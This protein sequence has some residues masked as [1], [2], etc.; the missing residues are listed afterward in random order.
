MDYNLLNFNTFLLDFLDITLV[1][2]IFYQVSFL[3]RNTRSTKLIMGAT[4][5]GVLYVLSIAWHLEALGQVFQ[6]I[7][8]VQ[9]GSIIIVILFSQEI[10]DALTSISLNRMA[11]KVNEDSKTIESITQACLKMS[12]NKVG[13]LILIGK[14]D[15]LYDLME[16]AVSLHADVSSQVIESIFFEP[17]LNSKGNNPLH[18]G[19]VIISNNKIIAAKVICKQLSE[20]N[21]LRVHNKGTRHSAGLGFTEQRDC[22]AIIISHETGNIT[23][24]THGEKTLW[25]IDR[26]DLLLEL[27]RILKMYE[28]KTSLSQTIREY[29][30][31]RKFTKFSSLALAILFWCFCKTNITISCEISDP[32]IYVANHTW[33]EEDYVLSVETEGERNK[34]IEFEIVNWMKVYYL[35]NLNIGGKHAFRNA[36]EVAVNEEDVQKQWDSPKKRIKA[37][38]LIAAPFKNDLAFGSVE[39][40]PKVALKIQRLTKVETKNLFRFYISGHQEVDSIEGMSDTVLLMPNGYYLPHLLKIDITDTSVISQATGQDSWQEIRSNDKLIRNYSDFSGMLELSKVK[41]LSSIAMFNNKI[42]IKFRVIV[43][44]TEVP[45][46]EDELSAEKELEAIRETRLPEEISTKINLNP[47]PDRIQIIQASNQKMKTTERLNEIQKQIEFY[48]R[49][50]DQKATE[51][52]KYKQDYDALMISY[53]NLSIA[54]QAKKKEIEIKRV[55]V[56]REQTLYDQILEVLEHN[57]KKTKERL[58]KNEEIYEKYIMAFQPILEIYDI[59]RKKA[60][61]RIA[62][63]PSVNVVSQNFKNI[64]EQTQKVNNIQ[65]SSV[66]DVED[67]FD[68]VIESLDTFLISPQTAKKPGS[69]HESILSKR[70]LLEQLDL[71]IDNLNNHLQPSELPVWLELHKVQT[72]VILEDIFL[73]VERISDLDGKISVEQDNVYQIA[74]YR[75]ALQESIFLKIENLFQAQEKLRSLLH[76]S[77][78]VENKKLEIL[79]KKIFDL[80]TTL[81]RNIEIYHA[82]KAESFHSFKQFTIPEQ[83]DSKNPIINETRKGFEEWPIK[84]LDY[85]QPSDRANFQMGYNLIKNFFTFDNNGWEKLNEST[86][87][88]EKQNAKN[89]QEYANLIAK[90]E[91]LVNAIALP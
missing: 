19:A 55:Q 32:N 25:N 26:A 49:K 41:E 61:V 27:K 5:I 85:T 22:V 11:Y 82:K 24:A 71:A 45:K 14:Q 17:N 86:L 44:D 56:P 52:R 36:V 29:L 58:V 9:I 6:A 76:E 3:F 65:S 62:F 23:L 39:T 81:Q 51:I 1:W 53:S 16:G 42:N 89:L 35:F 46:S 20:S 73:Q 33:Q 83:I 67:F 21:E 68:L 78:F 84:Y 74:P 37:D 30:Y 75:E 40:T 72:F 12:A 13:A 91:E 43:K 31:E 88:I 50:K 70:T 64:I 63:K 15:T 60:E 48:T 54:D 77:K 4:L 90:F 2:F 79:T 18:D 47:K 80:K 34:N 69:L 66:K 8:L 87:K 59:A 28:V 57:Y 38:L 7:N 10:K